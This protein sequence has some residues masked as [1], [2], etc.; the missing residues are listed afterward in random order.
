[1]RRSAR[2]VWDRSTGVLRTATARRR[3]GKDGDDEQGEGPED[4]QQDRVCANSDFDSGQ[5]VRKEKTSATPTY[6]RKGYQGNEAQLCE[7]SHT[8]LSIQGG[9]S[10]GQ[11]HPPAVR[12]GL[13]DHSVPFRGV[14][15]IQNESSGHASEGAHWA[16][17]EEGGSKPCDLAILMG[18]RTG[19]GAKSLSLSHGRRSTRL[20]ERPHLA[21]EVRDPVV[22][23]LFI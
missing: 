16:R 20:V 22:E 6:E 8:Q 15:A 9:G 13:G 1:M 4:E 11:P 18:S 14:L 7:S 12:C 5:Q 17:V 2:T 10:N 23:E 3:R 21:G 19:G